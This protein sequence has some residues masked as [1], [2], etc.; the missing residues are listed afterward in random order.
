MKM[1][2][3]TEAVAIPFVNQFFD[4][5]QQ[6]QPNQTTE[7]AA[8]AML[9]EFSSLGNGIALDAFCLSNTLATHHVSHNPVP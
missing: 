2:P 4:V 5:A 3:L 8:T 9:H 6:F 1:M 7:D